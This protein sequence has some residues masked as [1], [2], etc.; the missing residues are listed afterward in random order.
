M[1]SYKIISL[2]DAENVFEKHGWP[3]EMRFLTHALGDEQVAVTYRKMPK[4]SG[5][6]GSY[7]HY[8]HTQEEVVY[9][10]SGE[11][12]VKL[13]DEVK[14]LKAGQAIRIAPKTVRSLENM[15]EEPAELL[16]ISTKLPDGTDDV[17]KV[18]DF[19]PE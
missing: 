9:L 8:H 19:W 3:G 11:L 16:I 18:P 10:I 6:K 12:E 7:G 13:N 1:D 15:Q 4:N 2:D 17:G 14:I 5:G